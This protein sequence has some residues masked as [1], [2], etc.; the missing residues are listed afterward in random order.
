MAK[1]NSE[2]RAIA[3]TLVLL[4]AAVIINYI[5][6]GNLALAAPLLKAEWGFSASQLGILFSAFFWSYTLM[7]F[8]IGWLVDR[9]SVNGVMALG[10]LVWSLSTAATG[11]ATG[12]V[13]LLVLRLVLGL[14]ESV[15]FPASSKI[16][17]QHLP[18]H[19]RGFANGIIMAAIYWGSAVGTLGGGILIAKYGWRPTFIA[20]GLVGLLWLPAWAR[21]KP[22]AAVV[23][24]HVASAGV[25]SFAAILRKRSFW[26]AAV[27]HFADNYVLYFLVSWLPYYLVQERHLSMQSMVGIAGLLYAVNSFACLATGW[28]TDRCIKGGTSPTFAR[29]AAMAVGAILSTLS[30][31]AC[32]FATEGTYLWC[33]NAF[34]IGVGTLAAGNFVFGQTLAGPA[35]AGRWAGM[36]NGFANLA[37]I[38]GPAFTGILVDKTGHFGAAFGAAALV[39]IVGGVSWCFGVG[40]LEQVQWP[41]APENLRVAR[42]SS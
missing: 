29:K 35:A 13:S 40:K 24:A 33:L 36:Q 10:F 28:I 6:R 8:A 5:D 7:Q 42:A 9:F 20:I 27:G 3:P 16:C 31:T 1:E 19:A 18:E 32:A 2:L 4:V 15:M 11:L 17:A 34:A 38:V 23:H 25:P 39:M 26:G 37:G 12:L 21:W 30:L 41:D 14:G 22:G